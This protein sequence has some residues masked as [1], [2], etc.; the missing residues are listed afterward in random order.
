MDDVESKDPTSINPNELAKRLQQYFKP[1]EIAFI[2]SKSADI[3]EHLLKEPQKQEE[4]GP[5]TE[6]SVNT[7]T[8]ENVEILIKNHLLRAAYHVFQWFEFDIQRDNT[9]SGFDKVVIKSGFERTRQGKPPF[10]GVKIGLF[11]VLNLDWRES[12][13][14]EEKFNRRSMFT[15]QNGES[16]QLGDVFIGSYQSQDERAVVLMEG[17]FSTEKVSSR[18]GG[19]TNVDNQ[20]L[21]IFDSLDSAQKFV[22][23]F[24]DSKYNGHNPEAV[25]HNTDIIESSFRS[26]EIDP[27][28][29]DKLEARL[30]YGQEVIKLN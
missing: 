11:Q 19:R 7:E 4:P 18:N 20:I 24:D 28:I 27:K 22:A 15:R 12:Y 30:L 10:E 6:K 2:F 16:S 17:S 9:A 21:W 26:M 5:I 1:E 13:K 14:M 23:F 29:C 3:Q 8:A 25:E